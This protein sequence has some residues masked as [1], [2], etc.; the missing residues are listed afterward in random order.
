MP[1]DKGANTRKRMD[2]KPDGGYG[3]EFCGWDLVLL[4]VWFDSETAVV[5]S[6]T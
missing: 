3:F 6:K 2:I 1:E 4:W 5:M